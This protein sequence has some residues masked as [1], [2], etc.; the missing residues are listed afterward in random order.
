MIDYLYHY[1][2]L[3]ALR[4][5]LRNKTFRLSSLNN[6]DD[7]EEGE[8]S[9]FQKLGRFIYISSWTKNSNES[10]SL[11]NYSKGNAGVRIKMKIN[12]FKTQKIN[13][14]VKMH[15]KIVEVNEEFNL[16]LL[17]MMKNENVSFVPP[18]AELI[19]VT[20]TD[21]ERLLKPTV[22]NEFPGAHFSIQ[23]EN[24]GIF[25]RIEWQEQQEWRYRLNSMPVGVDEMDIFSEPDGHKSLL[26]KIRNR[27][28]LG[29]IDLPL[30]DNVF[31]DLEVLCS[32][33][34]SDD[35][36][37]ELNKILTQ[38]APNAVI[39]DSMLKIRN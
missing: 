12:P 14:Y 3:E 26:N 29:F 24:L 34:M 39:K 38:Y 27:E 1:T 16:G 9:D 19:R 8:T 7:L 4:L 31:E 35:S 13:D 32:P 30:K 28:D 15:D 17:D 18:R 25:K 37:N 20:Y 11:W 6:M 23:T 5:I 21:V 22:Y 2:N 33:Y 36:N 10:L